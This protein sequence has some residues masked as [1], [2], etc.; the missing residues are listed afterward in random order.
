V[1]RAMLETLIGDFDEADLDDAITRAVALHPT[2]VDLIPALFGITIAPTRLYGSTALNVMPGR[3]SV[4]LDCRLLPGDTQADLDREL[5]EAL[6]EDLPYEIE[7]LEDPPTGGTVANADTPL[8]GVIQRFLDEHDPG[9]ILLPTISTGFT[10]SHWVRQAW[11]T[12]SYGFW[13]M[14]HTPL[15]LYINGIH[16]KDERIHADD[17]AYGLE[18]TLYAARA[19]GAMSR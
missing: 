12:D 2:F 5:R 18:F 3:A 6:G 8:F 7:Y 1:T 10:D 13:P 19:I 17:L 14:R 15:E 4:A 9:A 16:N 11:G